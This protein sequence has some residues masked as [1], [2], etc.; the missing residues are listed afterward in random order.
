MLI[1][2]RPGAA[3]VTV[4]VAGDGSFAIHLEPGQYAIAAAPP[5]CGGRVEPSSV[6]VPAK[7]S[8]FFGLRIAR[9]P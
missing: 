9:S 7:G 1:F 5:A 6:Q 4:F 2:S 8:V 3:D